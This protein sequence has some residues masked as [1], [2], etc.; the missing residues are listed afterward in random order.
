MEVFKPTLND[1]IAYS[2]TA[3][4]TSIENSQVL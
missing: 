2:C 4:F 3:E 1:F